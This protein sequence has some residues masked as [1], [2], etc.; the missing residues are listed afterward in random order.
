MT[1]YPALRFYSSATFLPF[2]QI[3]AIDKLSDMRPVVLAGN[4]IE[5]LG[6]ATASDATLQRGTWFAFTGKGY[7]R[8]ERTRALECLQS[9]CDISFSVEFGRI[10]PGSTSVLVGQSS[11]GEP[12]WHLLYTG[13][14]LILQTDGGAIEIAAPFA[15]ISGHSYRI[16]IAHTEQGVALSID[17]D[18]IGTG[19]TSPLQ[20]VEHPLTIGGR[21]GAIENPFR[22]RIGELTI[23]RRSGTQAVEPPDTSSTF[24]VHDRAALEGLAA[25]PRQLEPTWQLIRFEPNR[26]QFTVEMPAPGLALHLDN[27]DPFW[28]V[29]V[30]GRERPLYRANF[31]FKALRLPAGPSVVEMVYDPYPI[32]WGWTAFYLAFGAML[33]SVVVPLPVRRKPSTATPIPRSVP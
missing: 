10:D 19:K 7:A 5:T 17:G 18:V 28:R 23:S 3:A 30:D 13:G 14:K 33:I 29:R 27:F 2:A 20:D 31:T 25:E 32:R 15:P 24:Y 8:L 9:S 4:R 26:V 21:A 12:G 1:E 16:A 11:A 6:E 22:G